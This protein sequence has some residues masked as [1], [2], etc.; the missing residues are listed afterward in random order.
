MTELDDFLSTFLPRQIEAEEAIHNGDV[1]PRLAL[2]SRNEPVTLLGALGMVDSDWATVE[3]TFRWVASKFSNCTSYEFELIAAGV[4]GDVAYT[5]GYE[6]TVASRDG[7]PPSPSVL[8]AT[9][10][11]RREDGEWKIVHRHADG[12]GV[13]LSPPG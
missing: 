3:E 11:Y 8:R 9:H 12:T 1:E 4:S 13:D 2:W 6:R 7:A 10:A 5:V